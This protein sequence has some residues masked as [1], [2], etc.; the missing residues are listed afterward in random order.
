MKNPKVS[1]IIPVYNADK[2]LKRCLES[3]LNQTFKEIEV[4]VIA[5]GCTDD[6]LNILSSYKKKIKLF[7][8]SNPSISEA[9]N[10]G[11]NKAL[12]DYILFF[13]A[14]DSMEDKMVLK[15]YEKALKSRADLIYSD[16]YTF[17]EQYG[18]REVT[19]NGGADLNNL[20]K[21][22]LGPQKLFKRSIIVKNN[23]LFPLNL[24]YEDIPFVMTYLSYTKKISKINVPLFNYVIHSNSEQT[25][26]DRRVF[27]LFKILDIV[28]SLKLPKKDLENVNVKTLIT[29]ALKQ[30]Y[31]H[32]HILGMEFIDEVFKYLNTNYPNWKECK[33]LKEESLIKRK[34]K[35]SKLLL[36]IYCSLYF[37]N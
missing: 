31:Q 20:Y 7:E 33:Y 21:I 24:K 37:I 9:R 18:K 36:K 30:K 4:L 14:D 8:L 26:I 3:V 2:Y 10:L 13:D 27:N 35:K 1:I 34:I 11:I 23:I 12:G 32:N 22:S 17:Y 15:L 29:F 25:T 5:N 16:Y 28:N 6:S 19:I